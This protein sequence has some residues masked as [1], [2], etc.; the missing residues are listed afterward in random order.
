MLLMGADEAGKGPVIGSMFV[1]G[2]VIDE[3]RFFDLA[4]LGVKDSKMLSPAK[5]EALA[6]KITTIA[7]DQYILEVR[8]EVIDELRLVMT[9][10]D[11]M[12]RS[13][14]QVVGRLHADRAILDAADVNAERF[15][16]AVRNHSKTSMDLIAEHKADQRHH[17]VSAA[18]I[19]A[20][21]RRD[22]SMRELESEMHCKI[23]S[24]Y[25]HDRDTI[26]FLSEW[27]RE[28]NDLPP[29]ARHSWTTAQRIKASFI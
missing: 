26:A 23:G 3:E 10:N 5:R 11:I 16:Q 13:F 24:G 6:R 17:V 12:V 8:A 21:V 29:C 4:V 15:A 22:Q 2:L 1:A 19:L 28:N 18:S 25:P 7:T 27:V 14:S 20:K 9:M